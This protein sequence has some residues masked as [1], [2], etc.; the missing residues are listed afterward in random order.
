MFYSAF[1]HYGENFQDPKLLRFYLDGIQFA[2][3]DL[4]ADATPS[5]KLK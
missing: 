1:S 5:G 3:G 2:L 4:E